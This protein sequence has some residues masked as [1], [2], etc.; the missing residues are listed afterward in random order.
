VKSSKI[1]E[2]LRKYVELEKKRKIKKAAEELGL[3]RKQKGIRRLVNY[4]KS[5]CLMSLMIYNL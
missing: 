1:E 4:E 2:K 3:E 5:R